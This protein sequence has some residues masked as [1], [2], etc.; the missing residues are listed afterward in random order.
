MSLRSFER[1]HL[2]HAQMGAVNLFGSIEWKPAIRQE[3]IHSNRE[4]IS[5]CSSERSWRLGDHHTILGMG[6]MMNVKGG[7]G[8]I[9]LTRRN[10]SW[11]ASSAGSS[12][13]A[14]GAQIGDRSKQAVPKGLIARSLQSYRTSVRCAAG[15]PPFPDGQDDRFSGRDTRIHWGSSD[16]GWL[17]TSSS[18]FS[19]ESPSDPEGNDGVS[20]RQQNQNAA[21]MGLLF[22]AA[23]SH[24]RYLGLTPDADVEEIKTAYR[25]LS[26]TYHPDTTSLPLEIAAQKFV[27]LKEAYTVLSN[28]EERRFYDWQLAQEVSKRQGGRFIWPY[29]GSIVTEKN[30]SV[31][32]EV[33][34]PD[35]N[36]KEPVDRLGGA[37]MELSDQAQ[38]A[39]CHTKC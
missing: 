8:L 39:L 18:S 35:N 9:D 26:K 31:T 30:G 6:F 33:W 19:S 5:R 17:G 3:R 25:K 37:N 13:V 27:R 14:W 4:I 1:A 2:A 16:E 21:F 12:G 24:Y 32:S 36:S 7:E 34:D 38:A 20:T 11:S 28:E 15:T 23:D 29:E 22:Q 10:G